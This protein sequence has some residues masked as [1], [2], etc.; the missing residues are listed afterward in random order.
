[1]GPHPEYF[2]F[3]P[4]DPVLRGLTSS[5]R[6]ESRPLLLALVNPTRETREHCFT[7]Y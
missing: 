1:M 5:L 4:R 2:F 6:G 7:H 3:T